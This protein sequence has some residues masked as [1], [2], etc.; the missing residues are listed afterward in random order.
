LGIQ[1]IGPA[2]PIGG[3]QRLG[4]RLAAQGVDGVFD[5]DVSADPAFVAAMRAALGPSAALIGPDTFLPLGPPFPAVP[6]VE[7][8]MYVVGGDF[9]S[10][11]RQL[12]AAGRSLVAT[13][14]RHQ[15]RGWS[16]AWVPYAAQET[17]L[18]LTAIAHSNGT[19]ASVTRQLFHY[20]VTNGVMG[21]SAM[22]P[23]GDPSRG[24][25]LAYRLGGR[26][27]GTGPVA[28]FRIPASGG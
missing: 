21:S 7:R 2:S 5:A 17:D 6:R 28:V 23:T 26:S 24:I 4:R 13:I 16:D 10:P 14:A 22:T 27:P 3:F 12:P 8:G 11:A 9:T 20:R 18:M 19:R 1:V 25:V 15:P